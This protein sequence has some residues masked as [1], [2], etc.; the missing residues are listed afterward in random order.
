[1]LR[2]T[3]DIILALSIMFSVNSCNSGQNSSFTGAKGEV[4]LI[5]LYLQYLIDGKLPEWEV[6]NMI[7][8]YYTVTQALKLARETKE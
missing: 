4:K 3:I 5:T 6:P 8:K 7:A 2:N 1:M